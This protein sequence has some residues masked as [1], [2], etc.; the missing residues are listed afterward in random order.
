M[1]SIAPKVPSTKGSISIQVREQQANV[2]NA[3]KELSGSV[4]SK[5]ETSQVTLQP[6]S[7]VKTQD[8]INLS[9]EDICAEE[10]KRLMLI[11]PDI[12]IK[13][14]ISDV[15]R[16]FKKRGVSLIHLSHTN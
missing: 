12:S 16:K 13:E 11:Q 4:S 1:E 14:C 8:E 5:E 3:D 7:N 9:H 2:P 6:S 15:R 10:I